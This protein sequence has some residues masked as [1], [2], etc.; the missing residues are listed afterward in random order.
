[1]LEIEKFS[2]FILRDAHELF[3]FF[4]WSAHKR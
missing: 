1:M 3:F 2:D 4:F